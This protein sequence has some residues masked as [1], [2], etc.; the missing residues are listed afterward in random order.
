MSSEIDFFSRFGPLGKGPKSLFS[1]FKVHFGDFGVPGLCG[2]SGRL[3]A[4]KA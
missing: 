2:R 3:Q 4:K 1:D